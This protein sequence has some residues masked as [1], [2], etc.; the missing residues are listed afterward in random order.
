MAD[1]L[2]YRGQAFELRSTPAAAADLREAFEAAHEQRY[3]Y[4]TRTP[5]SSS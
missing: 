3:G 1:D 4:A 5:P 2:R